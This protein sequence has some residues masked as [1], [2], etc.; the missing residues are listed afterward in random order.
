MEK[1]HFTAINQ[2]T[3]PPTTFV[4]DDFNKL[5]GIT[6]PD[7]ATETLTYNDNGQLIKSEKSTG[8]T[9]TYEWNDQGMLVKVILP[10]GEPVEYYYD[11]NQRLVS[12]KSS[13]GVD[14]FVQSGWD[15]VTEMDDLGKR[16]YY[17]GSSA[18]EDKDSVK[19]FHYNHRGDTAL[20]TDSEGNLLNNFTYEAYGKPTTNEGTPITNL[21]LKNSTDPNNNSNNST[22]SNNL[23]NL[24]V[25]ASGIR[26]DTKTNLHYMRFRWFSPDQMRF[27]SPDL[28]MDLNRYAYVSGNPIKYIDVLGL[29]D[30]ISEAYAGP[31]AFT[32]YIQRHDYNRK[33]Y[34]TNEQTS[35]IFELAGYFLR[36]FAEGVERKQNEWPNSL[37][38][39]QDLQNL[40][41]LESALKQIDDYGKATTAYSISTVHTFPI[42]PPLIYVGGGC[43]VV[44]FKGKQR[45]YVFPVLSVASG[46]TH[47]ISASII[48]NLQSF[49]QIPGWYFTAGAGPKYIDYEV[50]ATANEDGFQSWSIGA[51]LDHG[52]AITARY[53][54]DITDF[55]DF[56]ARNIHTINYI[57]NF[58]SGYF[59]F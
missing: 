58:T 23:P 46:E 41:Y 4:Y 48:Q 30:R 16:T 6:Y 49:D 40:K 9:T 13:D 24:F 17:T 59:P 12:R 36:G 3:T 20:V 15:I 32:G 18:V 8:E 19:Y 29:H 10:T 11:G 35:S 34:Q 44:F 2:P 45:S 52:F 22:N 33:K 50:G 39:Q 5:T 43:E 28:L 55:A 7:S 14:K 42:I 53:Y 27:I 26:Y 57:K 56:Y 54:I 37:P 31:G 1:N 38:S 51:N 25:G 47:S 21:T